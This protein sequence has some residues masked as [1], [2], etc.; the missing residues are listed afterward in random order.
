MWEAIR[1]ISIA[2]VKEGQLAFGLTIYLGL[3][4]VFGFIIYKVMYEVLMYFRKSYEEAITR[5]RYLED[6][7]GK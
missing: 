2:I 7:D 1:D 3:S 6:K 5:I 4:H